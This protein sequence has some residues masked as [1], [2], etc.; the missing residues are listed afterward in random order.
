MTQTDM[1]IQH[2]RSDILVIIDKRRRETVIIEIGITSQ[3]LFNQVRQK[4]FTNMIYWLV[5]LN[6]FTDALQ[7]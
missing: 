6:Y 5:K 2:D 7:G 3:D 4:N 1:K